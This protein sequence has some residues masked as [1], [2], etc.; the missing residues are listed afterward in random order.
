MAICPEGIDFD[1]MA[2]PL[3]KICSHCPL[4]PVPDCVNPACPAGFARQVLDYSRQRGFLEIPVA[5]SLIPEGETNLFGPAVAAPALAE[6]C[7]QCR[8]CRGDHSPDCVVA[9]VRSSLERTVIGWKIIYPGNL[10]EYLVLVREH[11]PGLA[12]LLEKAL[13]TVV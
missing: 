4:K 1:K 3:E 9:L 10:Q 5:H 2:A 12:T 8:Q 7:R 13:K 6:T 11:S